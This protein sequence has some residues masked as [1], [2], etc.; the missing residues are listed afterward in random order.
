M[1]AASAAIVAAPNNLVLMTPLPVSIG[2]IKPENTGLNNGS[3]TV[4]DGAMNDALPPQLAGELAAAE[5]VLWS[6]Q[7]RRG[8]ALRGAD[9]FLIPFSL[10][11]GGF[12]IFWETMVVAVNAPLFFSLFGLIFVVVGLYLIVGRFFVDAMQRA[13][14]FYAVTSDRVIIVTGLR[15]RTVR[16][17]DLETLGEVTLS[18]RRD[19][20]GSIVLG[21]PTPFDWMYGGMAGWPSWSGFGTRWVPRFEL[22]DNVRSVYDIIR[23]AKRRPRR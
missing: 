3:L 17:I 2:A 8:V 5:R 14:T 10:A 7:P 4:E 6:G 9:A 1:L 21:T 22:I 16:S 13:R 11:W 15:S 12:A 18:E 23:S 20:S 19:G